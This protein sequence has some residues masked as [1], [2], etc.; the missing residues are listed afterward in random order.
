[1]LRHFLVEL[2]E[3]EF[4]QVKVAVAME[5]T[6][7]KSWLRSVILNNVNDKEDYSDLEYVVQTSEGMQIIKP[8]QIKK[9]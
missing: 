2:S 9:E 6:T 4:A 1:M 3:D 8:N 7:I 5:H